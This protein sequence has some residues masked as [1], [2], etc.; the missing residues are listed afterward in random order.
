MTAPATPPAGGT[1]PA[2][3]PGGSFDIN[4]FA[5][6]ILAQVGGDKDAA[7]RKLGRELK[8]ARDRRRDAEVRVQE[9]ESK[10]PAKDA[11]IIVGDDAKLYNSIKPLN[12]KAED[13]VAGLKERDTLRTENTGIKRKQAATEA[14]A[15]HKFKPGILLD[16]LNSRSMDL[17][18]QKAKVKDAKGV[19]QEQEVWHVRKQGDDKATWTPLK[20]WAESELKDYL[21]ALKDDGSSPT[22]G[23]PRFVPV[24]G[25]LP[26]APGSK[27]Q[28][29]ATELVQGHISRRYAL[30]GEE[31]KPFGGQAQN[32]GTQK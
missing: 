5:A 21:P 32:A 26:A 16:Q 19:E 3:S 9:L 28:G 8:K 4:A 27:A 13:I 11:V 10:L 2:P 31:T 24:P 20:D 25:S 23:E 18:T 6:S 29:S 22:P 7:I 1:P 17:A 12:L 30:P 14:G 15:V